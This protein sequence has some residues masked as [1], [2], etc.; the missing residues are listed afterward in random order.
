MSEY[1]EEIRG[2][3]ESSPPDVDLEYIDGIYGLLESMDVELDPDPLELGPQRLQTKIA[4]VRA[5]RSRLEKIFLQVAHDLAKT[6]RFLGYADPILELRI[7]ELLATDIEVR[8]GPSIAD[9]RALAMGRCRKL[10]AEVERLKRAVSEYESALVVIRSKKVDLGDIRG[11]LGDQMKLC[12]EQLTL[13]ERWGS[14]APKGVKKQS[15]KPGLGASKTAE[16]D[17]DDLLDDLGREDHLPTL[18]EDEADEAAE[19][20]DL[21]AGGDEI[22]DEEPE[23][24]EIQAGDVVLVKDVGVVPDGTYVVGEAEDDD[25]D[26][27]DLDES[28]DEPLPRVELDDDEDLGAL[29]AALPK[30][31]KK[32]KKK[33]LEFKDHPLSGLLCEACG[34]PQRTTPHGPV[35]ANG[36]GGAAGLT[37][38][39][40]DA[41]QQPAPTPEPEQA[42][43]PEPEVA[44][45]ELPKGAI[46]SAQD[47]LPSS[48]PE[49]EVEAML[50]GLAAT[51]SDGPQKTSNFDPSL[52]IDLDSVLDAFD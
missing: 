40:W 16:D 4:E 9:R 7:Q 37:K 3:L 35:C 34:E 47:I 51:L 8:S 29:L 27:V 39:E 48:S 20:V 15:L 46:P 32:K 18:D 42:A 33:A 6:K 49:E 17:L 23:E 26:L 30:K 19:D 13:G 21:S 11:R 14:R 52:D 45:V 2:L 44:A 28:D 25:I 12:Q 50:L 43:P 22:P 10:V 31:P 24:P 1:E 41:S 38:K 5:M 36:H